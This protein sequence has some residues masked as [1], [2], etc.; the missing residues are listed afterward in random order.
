MLFESARYDNFLRYHKG[1]A[2][3]CIIP[4]SRRIAFSA[5]DESGSVSYLPGNN[6][7]KRDKTPGG[8]IFWIKYG[9]AT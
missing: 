9:L 6:A 7:Q 4:P 2:D 3:E 1:I 5:L 8:K